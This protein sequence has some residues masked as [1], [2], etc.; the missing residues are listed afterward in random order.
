[1]RHLIRYSYIP[2]FMRVIKLLF[3]WWAR[4]RKFLLI[5]S[6]VGFYGFLIIL[7]YADI[8]LDHLVYLQLND[9][10]KYFIENSMYVGA[11]NDLGLCKPSLL[12]GFLTLIYTICTLLLIA[13]STFKPLDSII[14]TCLLG[15]IIKISWAVYTGS[16]VLLNIF[17]KIIIE[18]RLGLDAKMEIFN[19]IIRESGGNLKI[20]YNDVA[21]LLE[22]VN[23]IAGVELILRDYI[24]KL[25]LLL[26]ETAAV[27]SSVDYTIV[28]WAC[29]I[30][31]ALVVLCM[32]GGYIYVS[33]NY[34]SINTFKTNG[35][36]QIKAAESI[37]NRVTE[38][39]AVDNKIEE[40]T[41]AILREDNKIVS[42]LS[43]RI[44]NMREGFTQ[45]LSNLN[46]KI[47]NNNNTIISSIQELNKTTFVSVEKLIKISRQETLKEVKAILKEYVKTKI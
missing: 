28:Y 33:N 3:V 43:Q 24:L 32:V 31:L 1:M 25:N 26:N 2:L 17:N 35:E 9:S 11:L 41:S 46:E 8:S 45:D 7:N 36:G 37:N 20:N 34:V 29:G 18:R 27:S 14:R 10:T 22:N 6:P 38:L 42:N 23:N 39:V 12:N 47:A 15:I 16:S 5:L 40:T 4:L 21:S 13:G 30:T 44:T 19:K